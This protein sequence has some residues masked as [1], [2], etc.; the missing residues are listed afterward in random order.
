MLTAF[1]GYILPWG[2]MSFWA[3]TVIINMTSIIP[4]IGEW[5]T[6]FLWGGYSVNGYNLQRFFV[7]H[8]LIWNL[9]NG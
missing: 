9:L 6:T 1:L 2:Q 7:L 5:L 4:F 8:F 3:A